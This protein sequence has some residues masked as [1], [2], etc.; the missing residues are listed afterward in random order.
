VNPSPL[1]RRLAT[2]AVAMAVGLTQLGAVVTFVLVWGVNSPNPMNSPNGVILLAECVGWI[3]VAPFVVSQAI[4]RLLHFD[5]MTEETFWE[6]R[7]TKVW[8]EIGVGAVALVASAFIP[9]GWGVLAHLAVGLYLVLDGM[10]LRR[11]LLRRGT[12]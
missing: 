12:P 6:A 3:L 9:R 8:A 5:W 1:R 7:R 4:I 10:A 2:L 11:K